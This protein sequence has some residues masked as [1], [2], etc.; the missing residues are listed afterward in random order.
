MRF[1][2]NHSTVSHASSQH[3][4]QVSRSWWHYRFY[5]G[6]WMRDFKQSLKAVRLPCTLRCDQPQPLFLI[7]G[8]RREDKTALGV[9][10]WWHMIERFGLH[11]Q[12]TR[13][14]F[15]GQNLFVQAIWLGGY[16]LDG[17][18]NYLIIFT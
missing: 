6:R 10:R 12:R 3:Q 9:R 16:T 1:G 5:L 15:P 14:G 13:G 17:N 8:I 11:S 4:R 2:F 18:H 7:D